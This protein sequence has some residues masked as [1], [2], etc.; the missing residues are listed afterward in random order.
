MDRF[1]VVSADCHA[2]GRPDDFRPFIES[3]YLDAFDEE[4]RRRIELRAESLQSRSIRA[5]HRLDN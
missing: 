1:V 3:Q 5:Q 4:N 2:V